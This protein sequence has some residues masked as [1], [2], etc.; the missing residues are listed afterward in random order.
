MYETYNFLNDYIK[1]SENSINLEKNYT[2]ILICFSPV[3]P[4]FANEC[5]SDLKKDK[6]IKWPDFDLSSLSN[7][8]VNFVI[9]VNGKKRSIFK[10]KK[11]IKETDLLEKIKKDKIIVRYLEKKKIKK[12]IFVQNRLMNILTDE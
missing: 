10:E 12:I 9:Q 4:H 6:E 2:K 5:L 11:G 1:T 7:E 3:I 8:F